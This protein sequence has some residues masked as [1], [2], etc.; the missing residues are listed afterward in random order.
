MKFPKLSKADISRIL[1]SAL[2]YSEAHKPTILTAIG[3]GFSY[4]AV[5]LVPDWEVSSHSGLG[6]LAK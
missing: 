2:A 5:T 1:N 4:A 6:Y 3:I